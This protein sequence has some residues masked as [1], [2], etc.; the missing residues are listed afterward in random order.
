M[1]SK[2]FDQDEISQIL[3]EKLNIGVTKSTFMRY[4]QYGFIFAPQKRSY[5][6]GS[7]RRVYYHPLVP[8]EIATAFLLFRGDWLQISSNLRLARATDQDVFLGRLLFYRYL[9]SGSR[10]D[11]NLPVPFDCDGFFTNIR[12]YMSMEDF[13]S[14]FI[15]MDFDNIGKFIDAY[16]THVL[17][18]FLDSG[19]RDSYLKYVV[20]TYRIT[21]LHLAEVMF[22]PVRKPPVLKRTIPPHIVTK[23]MRPF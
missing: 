3:K 5:T 2:Y 17:Q 22:Q 23:D 18:P 7:A 12:N 19:I 15:P 8:V 13:V 9:L 11:W 6:Y 16:M 21:F 10:K 1:E 4:N 14:D 20:D